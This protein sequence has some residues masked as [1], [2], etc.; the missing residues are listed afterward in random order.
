MWYD[1]IIREDGAILL[2]TLEHGL[3]KISL[4]S[5]PFKDMTDYSQMFQLDQELRLGYRR[6]LE[7]WHSQGLI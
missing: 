5:F 1:S 6:Y 3:V 7:G 4:D 2:E